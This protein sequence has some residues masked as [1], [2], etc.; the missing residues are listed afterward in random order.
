MRAGGELDSEVG[1]LIVRDQ[2]GKPDY[3][4]TGKAFRYVRYDADCSKKGLKKMGL[5]HIKPESVASL[6]SVKGMGDLAEVGQA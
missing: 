4:S 3:S 5:G 6:D 1:D 2:D